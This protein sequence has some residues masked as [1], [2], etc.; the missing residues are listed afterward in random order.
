[1]PELWVVDIIDIKI[2]T[3][4]SQNDTV[5]QSLTQAMTA[6]RYPQAARIHLFTNGSATNAVTDGRTGMLLCFSGGQKA[7]ACMAVGKHCSNYRT[8]A[9]ALMQAA[10]E[11]QSSDHDCK[12][13][14]F[15]FDALSV[16]QAYQN[17]KLPNLVKDKQQVTATRRTVLQWV[18]AM[19]GI[20]GNEQADILQMRAPEE[21]SVTT[22]SALAK[23][24]LIRELTMPK[25]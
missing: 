6:E 14:V 17:H 3:T 10:S 18:P 21:N 2:N 9:E 12:Q 11:V 13:V 5:K 23:R 22:M 8:E 25:S 20:S 19:C 1:M 16:L 7:T 15:L 24:R 4:V